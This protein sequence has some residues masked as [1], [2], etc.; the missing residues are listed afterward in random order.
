M[1]KHQVVL[2]LNQ[3]Q[4][5]LLDKTIAKGEA[6]SREALVRKALRAYAQSRNVTSPND[7]EAQ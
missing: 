6:T 4:T 7:G 1:S 2:K 3:Q 5:E